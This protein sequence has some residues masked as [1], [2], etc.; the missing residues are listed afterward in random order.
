MQRPPTRW[1]TRR[2]ADLQTQVREDLLDHRGLQD[3]GDD[4]QLAAAVRAVRHID[5]EGA[6]EQRLI[7]LL[8]DL[9]GMMARGYRLKAIVSDISILPRKPSGVSPK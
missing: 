5:L 9:K 7:I 4:L 1:R 6:L 3:G 8:E 2:R